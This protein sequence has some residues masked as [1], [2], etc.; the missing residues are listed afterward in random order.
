[1]KIYV[2]T[3]AEWQEL[4]RE[5]LPETTAEWGEGGLTV[6][7]APY[8]HGLKIVANGRDITLF[9]AD[10]TSFFK[11][12]GLILARGEGCYE[13]TAA[14][15]FRQL[16]HMLDCSRNGVTSIAT[17]KKLLRMS[18]LMGYNAL[19]LYTEDTYEIPDEPYFGRLRGRYSQDE[20]RLLDDYAARFD[21][22]IVP[23]IQTLAHLDAIFRWPVYSAHVHDIENV[24][25]V[26][27]E[28]TY[29]L[30]EKMLIAMKGALRSR[31]IHI[32]MD[33]AHKLGRGKY[34]DTYGYKTRAE[35]MKKHL[36]RVVELCRKHGYEPLM[37]S[38]MFFRVCSPTDAYN[39]DVLLTEEVIR[40]VPEGVNL[41]FW[42]YGGVADDFFD[43]ML[44]QHKK[45]GRK[46]SYYGGAATWYGFVPM[47]DFAVPAMKNA[48][49]AALKHGVDVLFN[50]YWGNDGAETSFFEGF[51]TIGLFAAA[52]W[53]G[54]VSDEAAA[55][56]LA[57]FGASFDDFMSLHLFHK[58]EGSTRVWSLI[59][60][61][62]LYGDLLQGAWDKNIPEGTGAYFTK[63]KARM[64]EN[65]R[66]NPRW[67]YIFDVMVALA[68]V[69]SVRAEMGKALK[70]AYDAHDT[71]ALRGF[72]EVKIP[73]LIE[74]VKHF[75]LL[76]RARWM[77]DNKAFGFDVQDIRL[78]ALCGRLSAATLMIR[79]YLAGKIPVIEEL[80]EERLPQ[81]AGSEGSP[82][83]VPSWRR[84][85]T[86]SNL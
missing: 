13:R 23:C 26:D 9:C 19:N 11:G 20:L 57:P 73:A 79:D 47:Q 14:L 48:L 34:L 54:E 53:C 16:G 28:R 52:A 51:P 75:H 78:S 63:V 8:E 81:T 1:M 59:H 31:E 4:V 43:R 24:L 58:Y 50:T 68:D 18:A 61:Y 30:I 69:L 37:W 17:V 22:T 64:E 27:E 46:V 74:K 36:A 72:A 40:S 10:K 86:Y 84:I 5:L 83:W 85:V 2:N 49:T 77:Q 60:E 70:A 3:T 25:L 29:Q 38:D 67:A 44:V 12:I 15:R 42:E 76:H 55:E 35:I 7:T 41:V 65:A 82:T 33:E 39:P 62:I 66:R 21:I 32:G 6:T 80:A 71:V 45:F 56:V